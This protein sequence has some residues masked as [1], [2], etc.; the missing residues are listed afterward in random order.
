MRHDGVRGE[1]D[2]GRERKHSR[3]C[4]V[5]YEAV[6]QARDGRKGVAVKVLLTDIIGQVSV[7]IMRFTESDLRLSQKIYC[8]MEKYPP[9]KEFL[10]QNIFCQ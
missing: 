9:K 8:Q 3:H 1:S 5:R 10:R 7:E 4:A 2:R 6:P